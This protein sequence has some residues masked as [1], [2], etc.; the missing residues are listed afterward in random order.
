MQATHLVNVNEMEP[1]DLCDYLE[2][3]SY[4]G[5]QRSLETVSHYM[6]DLSKGA[7]DAEKIQ[8]VSLLY[9]RLKDEVEQ[10]M[11]NDTIIIFPLIRN[12]QG[13]A[14]GSGR[15]LPEDMIRGMHKKIMQLLER[16]RQ[17]ANN[18]INKPNWSNAFRVCFNELYDLEQQLQQVIYIK[19]NTLLPKVEKQHET[20]MDTAVKHDDSL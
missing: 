13:K 6:E 19:E 7:E 16:I 11:R 12:Q 10:L 5:I 4:S 15:K 20:T 1:N 8:L 14:P 18:Y 3:K 17:Q 2:L 9:Q